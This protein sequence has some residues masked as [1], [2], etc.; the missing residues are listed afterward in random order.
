MKNLFFLLFFFTIFSFANN[1]PTSSSIKEVTVYLNGAQ[2]TRTSFIKV[3]MGTTEFTLDKLS[4]YIDE[5]SIQ[6]SGLK[7]VS[8]LSISYGI[9]YLSKQSQTIEIEAFQAQIKS[10]YDAIQEEDDLIA[11]YTEELNVIQANRQLGNDNQVVNLEKLKQFSEYYRTRITEIKNKTYTSQKKKSTLQNDISEI[12]KQLVELNVNDKVQTGQIKLKLN[13]SIATQLD[14]VIKYNVGNAG[15]F[16]I[17]DLKANKINAPLELA[18]KAHVYQT[19]GSDWD[20]IKLTLSTSDPNTNN[21]K[22]DLNSKYLNFIRARS[23]YY[24]N[25]ATKTYNYKYN[26]LVKK[27]TGIVTDESGQPLPG[28]T[29]LE[30]GTSNGASTDFDGKYT[31]TVNGGKEL[32]FSYVGYMSETLPIHSSIMNLNMA[33]DSN[34]LD[35]VVV[36]ALG[37]KRKKNEL[38]RSLQGNV[39]G[40]QIETNGINQF[41]LRGNRSLNLI[42]NALVV[43]DGIVSDSSALS[44]INPE[45]IANVEF[46]KGAEGSELYGSQGNNGAYIVTT[47]KGEYTTNGD[48]IDQGITNTRFEIKKKYSIPTDGDVNVIEIENYSVPATYAYFAAPVLNENVFLTVKIGNWEQYNLLPAEANVYFEG[49]YSGKTNLNPMA[50]TDSLTVSLGVDPNVVVKRTELSDFKKNQYIGNNK[51]ISK[52]YEIELKNTKQSAIDLVLYD[53]I[54]VSQNRDIKVEDVET[55]NSKYEE[56]KGI[57]EWKVNLKPNEKSTFKFSYAIKYPKIQRINL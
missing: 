34:N 10:L 22:P 9:D 23:N 52:T 53:R 19:T 42:H 35:E 39:S 13:T 50:T 45:M 29:I 44:N 4:P 54:P 49:S 11:G 2:I 32:I 41:A 21:V 27:I 28:A 30:K 31:L 12:Q 33:M 56:D 1:N 6:I 38:E 26:P 47:K 37:I 7:N 3:P 14:L 16:P 15:W 43:I 20:D 51:I 17:Y 55:G 40:L 57:L 46:M 18:Y 25:R 5:S 8:I 48:V 24:G 36:T